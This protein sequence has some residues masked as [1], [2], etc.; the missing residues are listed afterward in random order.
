MHADTNYI[1]AG[2]SVQLGSAAM[3]GKLPLT[4]PAYSNYTWTALN[5]QGSPVSGYFQGGNTTGF[6]PVVFPV[7]TTRYL[8]SANTIFGCTDT[9]SVVVYVKGIQPEISSVSLLNPI[10]CINQTS[11]LSPAITAPPFVPAPVAWT[12][13]WSPGIGLSDSTAALPVLSFAG[14]SAINYTLIVN[15]GGCYDTSEVAITFVA[16]DVTVSATAS[17]GPVCI[18]QSIH[19]SATATG[20][21]SVGS[22]FNWISGERILS[23]TDSVTIAYPSASGLASY[24]MQVT[25]AQGCIVRDTVLVT[26]AGVQPFLQDFPS[27]GLVLC[28]NQTSQVF[29]VV[30]SD[31][32]I[33]NPDFSYS[34]SPGFGL[35]DSTIAN[36]EIFLDGQTDV[37]YTLTVSNGGCIDTAQLHVVFVPAIDVVASASVRGGGNLLEMCL[38]DTIDLLANLTPAGIQNAE[39]GWA[40]TGIFD[41]ASSQTYA[42]PDQTGYQN[43]VITATVGV[44]CFDRDTVKVR[45]L[46][47]RPEIE[48]LTATP[49]PACFGEITSLKA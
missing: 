25:T 12:Y 42:V 32:S 4:D 17:P 18:G 6:S 24:V 47:V 20:P 19:L 35:S 31:S 23:A 37:L 46:G 11:A 5:L 15:N 30:N 9:A 10:L 36:P 1:C 14:Q 22:S 26:I 13:N 33:S 29:A 28:S 48:E 39:Y 38:G 21:G 2:Q 3:A 16:D 7:Q 45:I 44:N 43:Y 49:N 34:W 41:A 27:G 8:L 40:G